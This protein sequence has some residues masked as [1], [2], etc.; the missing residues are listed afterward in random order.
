MLSR[1]LR[2]MIYIIQTT[3]DVWLYERG[4]E[5]GKKRSDICALC[6]DDGLVLE[7]CA[8]LAVAVVVQVSHHVQSAVTGAGDRLAS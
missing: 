7:Q 4:G 8:N 6:G 1:Q 5:G 2:E 3:H